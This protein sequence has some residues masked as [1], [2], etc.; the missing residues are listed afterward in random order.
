MFAL[1]LVGRLYFIQIVDGADFAGRATDQYTRPS[2]GLYD[3][4]TIYFQDKTNTLIPAADLA[5]GYTVAIN[6]TLISGPLSVNSTST[7]PATST[8]QGIYQALNAIVPLDQ[9]TFLTDVAKGAAG[10]TYEQIADQV[11]QNEADSISA[12]KIA[13]VGIYDERWRSYPLGDLASHVVGFVGY[14]GTTTDGRYGLEKEYD[15]TLE[16]QD[17][18]VYVNLFAQIFS[19]IQS[20]TGGNQEGDIVTSI[21]P[22]VEQYMEQQLQAVQ[23]QYHSQVTGGIIIDPETGEIYAMGA[24]PSFDPNHYGDVNNI[25]VFTNPLVQNVYEMGSVIKSLTMAAGLDAG[26]VT[27]STTYNDQGFLK[28][29]GSTIWNYDLKG[30]GPNT[31]MQTVLDDSLNTGAATVALKLGNQRFSNYMYTF[32]LASSTGIDLPNEAH[33]LVNNLQ[34]PRDIEHAT[35]AYG[36]GI[37][38]TPISTVRALC[39]L[40]NGGT[41]ITPHVVTQIDYTNGLTKQMDY[42]AG[43]RV[44]STSTAVEISQM[45][46]TVYQQALVADHVGAVKFNN[47]S[48]AS[49]TGTAQIA[50][51]ATG[52]YYPDEYLNSFFGFFPS[53]GSHARFL[54]FLYTYEPQNVDFAS[55]SLTP[56]FVNLVKYLINYYEIP[57]DR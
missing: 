44:I 2:S 43:P 9:H 47:Y 18:N 42:P 30:R 49:K 27:A 11:P 46:T 4:G 1:V 5:T 26:V 16:R 32:G 51:P 3:R 7:L 28:I 19:N 57:P 10:D 6:P 13:A 40:A 25:G 36:Q 37:A 20:V 24:T 39:A 53:T 15:S 45:L 21:D 50:D 8:P 23:A 41:L 52:G 35:A 38:L 55:Q 17:D 33:N 48:V 31:T 29:D 56:S 12:L 22:N 14:D 54:I 34:S